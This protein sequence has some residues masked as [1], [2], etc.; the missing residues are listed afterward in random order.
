MRPVFITGTGTGIGKTLVSS[1]VVNALE[2]DYWKPI[3]P[4]L[5]GGTDSEFVQSMRAS[6][7]SY[8]HA[9]LYRLKLPASPHLAARNEGI[10]IT[11]DSIVAA[12]PRCTNQL[13]IEGPGGMMVPLNDK[14]FVCDLIR[15]LNARVILVSRNYLGSINHS[16]LTANLCKQMSLDVIGWI[17]ND[18]FGN[19][20]NE[21]ASWSNYPVI[22]KLPKLDVLSGRAIAVHT[23]L[24]KEKLKD[25]LL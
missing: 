14:E 18:E 24:V 10:R 9:E 6:D 3:Q 2:A 5:E 19:Y 21:V 12:L 23:G 15:K 13:V 11:A 22:C 1:I 4:G 20:E 17:F 8:I 7:K 16:L 25:C